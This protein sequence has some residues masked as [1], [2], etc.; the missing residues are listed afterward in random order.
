MNRLLCE[1]QVGE[2]TVR[3]Y[4]HDKYQF[5]VKAIAVRGSGRQAQVI[6]NE[7]LSLQAAEE[8]MPVWQS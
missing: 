2:W 3:V 7:K 8:W 5:R 1:R 6:V 4:P